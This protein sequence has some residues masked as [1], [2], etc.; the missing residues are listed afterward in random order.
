MADNNDDACLYLYNDDICLYIYVDGWM[1]ASSPTAVCR[2]ETGK[3]STPCNEPVGARQQQY[4]IL[5]RYPKLCPLICQALLE[6]GGLLSSRDGTEN[7]A[8][9]DL[10]GQMEMLLL[11]IKRKTHM[12]CTH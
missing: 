10:P 2:K 12:A 1:L 11:A 6:S 8:K 9:R 3:R 7:E 4:S 5:G